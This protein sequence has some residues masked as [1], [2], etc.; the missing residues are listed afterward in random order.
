MTRLELTRS[1]VMTG[2][3]LGISVAYVVIGVLLLG[4]GLTSRFAWWVKA[5]AIVVTS[6]FFIEVFF[7]TKGL[8]G[9]PGTGAAAGAVSVAVGERGR[10]R[11]EDP[12]SRRDLSLDRGTRRE[13]RADRHAALLPAAVLAAAR[14]TLAQ[15]ARRDHEGQSAAG[16]GRR[17]RGSGRAAERQDR[18]QARRRASPRPAA[19]WSIADQAKLLQRRAA[20]G[21]RRDAGADACRQAAVN[22]H[23]RGLRAGRRSSPGTPARRSRRLP[24]TRSSAGV[25]SAQHLAAMQHD[26]PVG[27]GDLVAQMRRPQH[28]DAR[29]RCAW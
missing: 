7:A 13:Q 20:R 27:V 4:M 29:A 17:P 21:V 19:S 16:H 12:R 9:W 24:A 15:G 5:A 25:V 23:G 26:H 10:A 8:L 1:R 18:R 28:R 11:S 22:S 3:V 2:T 14:R 6:V